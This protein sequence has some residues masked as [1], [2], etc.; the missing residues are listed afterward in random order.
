[1]K[2][3]G[4]I[5]ARLGSTR[6]PAKTLE[7]IEGVPAIVRMLERVKLAESLT[8]LWL[9]TGDDEANDPLARE[10][11]SSGY[12]VFRGSE[13]DVL[14]RYFRLAERLESD[15]VVRLTGDCQL[16]DPEIIDQ[17]VDTFIATLPSYEYGSNIF[18]ATYPDGLDV[19]VFTFHALK[20][21]AE[22]S[23][24]SLEREH[25]TMG[26][27]RQYHESN[28]PEILSVSAPADFSHLRW[29]LDY[30]EDLDFIRAVYAELLPE[31]PEFGWLDVLALLTR[32]PDILAINAKHTRNES[33]IAAVEEG[34][35]QD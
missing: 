17:T 3:V 12:Q 30:Q 20:K 14:D 24:N 10:V 2:V 26:I 28:R 19:E 33:L 9:A 34:G 32:R 29:T 13:S 4:I 7:P 15:V 31:N 8:D 35:L 1:M 27:H 23:T 25:V 5:Q 18:P 21:A 6:L 22:E 16:H 11:E